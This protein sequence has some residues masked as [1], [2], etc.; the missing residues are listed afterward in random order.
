M[1]L[2]KLEP[3]PERVEHHCTYSGVY[4]MDV[5]LDNESVVQIRDYTFKALVVYD[6]EYENASIDSITWIDETPQNSEAIEAEIKE[7]FSHF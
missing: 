1:G 4:S 7:R 6:D 5:N 3:Y 2:L